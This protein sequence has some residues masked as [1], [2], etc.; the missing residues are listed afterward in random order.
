MIAW[1]QA[2]I[3]LIVTALLLAAPLYAFALVL[4]FVDG[5]ATIAYY[6]AV[7]QIIPVPIL[8]LASEVVSL[9]VVAADTSG[10]LALSI[11]AA[12]GLAAGGAA[13]IAAILLP[14]AESY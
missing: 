14:T 7:A 4:A 11:T 13:L 3:A 6:E 5:H 2:R 1:I 9:L 10:H 8:A 12:A